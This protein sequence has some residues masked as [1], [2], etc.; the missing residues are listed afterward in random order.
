VTIAPMPTMYAVQTSEI[1]RMKELCLDV[2]K[3]AINEMQIWDP[4]GELPEMPKQISTLLAE[5]SKKSKEN[6]LSPDCGMNAGEE[7]WRQQLSTYE[8]VS[9]NLSEAAN[10]GSK[11]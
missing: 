3:V 9:P 11:E 2:L 5:E 10:N 6:G 4:D 1:E 8:S 7:R